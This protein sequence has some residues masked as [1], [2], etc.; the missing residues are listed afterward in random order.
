MAAGGF[1]P[2][3]ICLPTCPV[4]LFVYVKPTSTDGGPP[5]PA[6]TIADDPSAT[7]SELRLE[8]EKLAI[9]RERLELERDRLTSERDQLKSEREWQGQATGLHVGVGIFGLA[10]ATALLVGGLVGF[11]AGL[12]AGRQQ[13]PLPRHVVVG[14]HFLELLARTAPRVP[15]VPPPD[16]EKL[17]LLARYQRP[18]GKSAAGNL[19]IVR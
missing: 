16:A 5:E 15:T 10:V 1:P 8:R 18:P 13:A 17:D 12:E 7:R 11:N 9:E 14:R 19:T 6:R 4:V 2:I 3:A